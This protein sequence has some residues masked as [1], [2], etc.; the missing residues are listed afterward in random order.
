MIISDRHNAWHDGNVYSILGAVISVTEI[1][2]G[3]IKILCNGRVSP[4]IDFV[5]K[6]LDLGFYAV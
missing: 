2:I 4:S 1:G 5:F 6:M 3:I